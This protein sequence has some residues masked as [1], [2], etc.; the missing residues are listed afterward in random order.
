MQRSL[1]KPLLMVVAIFGAT[2]LAYPFLPSEAQKRRSQP[3]QQ[4][5][6]AT[7][8]PVQSDYLQV[9]RQNAVASSF[10]DSMARDGG[11]WRLTRAVEWNDG[12]VMTERGPRL[13]AK[14]ISLD[15]KNGDS[16]AKVSISEYSSEQDARLPLG[17]KISQGEAMNCNWK[18]CGDE[19]LAY[20][21]GLDQNGEGIGFGGL[22]FRKGLFFVAVYST[23]EEVAKRFAG[24]AIDAIEKEASSNSRK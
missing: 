24:Y 13:G 14:S 3:Q 8:T 15:V 7:A 4:T 19:G 23:S 18:E 20:Y 11:D 5:A 17:L 21:K 22:R 10:Y 12:E 2:M 9:V 6:T 1:R 16:T